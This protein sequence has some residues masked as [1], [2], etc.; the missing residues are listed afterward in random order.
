[1]MKLREYIDQMG[2]DQLR[3]YAKRCSISS[4]ICVCTSST[5]AKIQVF[6]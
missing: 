4:T 5:R 3:S 2:D 6:H 1:M